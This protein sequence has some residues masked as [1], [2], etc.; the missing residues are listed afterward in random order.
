MHLAKRIV[1][2]ALLL[3]GLAL[4]ALGAWFAAYLGSAGAARFAVEPVGATPLV[5]E[6]GIL[7][8]TELPVRIEVTPAAGSSATIA[9]G[10]P[11]DAA[12]V[13]EGKALDRVTAV[14]LPA[15]TATVAHRD[16]GSGVDMTTVDVWRST[17]TATATETVTIRQD[18]A[19]E[20]VVIAPVGNGRLDAVTVTW[21]RSAWFKQ[22]VAVT[23]AGAGLAI[24]G[25]LLALRRRRSRTT[26]EVSA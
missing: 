23:V 14:D 15:K 13:L 21:T 25:A 6:P 26:A 3:A 9:V 17:K 7:N 12:S 4:I 8:R 11:A 16:G 10:T 24:V 18:T 20:T 19:P 5:L 2:A 1:G 22:A